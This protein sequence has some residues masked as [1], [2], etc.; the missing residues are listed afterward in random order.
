MCLIAMAVDAAPDLPLVIAANRDEFFARPTAAAGWWSDAPGVLAGRDLEGGG[1]WMGVTRGGRLAAATNYRDPSIKVEEPLSRGGL[2]LAFLEGTASPKDFLT[3]LAGEAGRYGPF[4][5][6]AGVPGELWWTSSQTREAARI[7]SG[8]H[9]LSNRL[10]DSP[11]PKVRRVREGLEQALAGPRAALDQALLGI[12]SD[13]TPG[14]AE[15]LPDTGVGPV[16]EAGLSPIFV[17][18]P[19]YGTRCSTLL[20]IGSDGAVRFREMSWNSEGLRT[21]EVSERYRLTD[22]GLR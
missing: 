8:V 5:L 10:L 13:R 21:G 6:V 17:S 7:P 18:L 20:F 3:S 22:D 11:W 2:V 4:C 1:T 12:L 16:L 14:A 19:G 9:A 15:D